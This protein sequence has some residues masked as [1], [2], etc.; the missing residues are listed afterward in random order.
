MLPAEY[1][2]ATPTSLITIVDYNGLCVRGSTKKKKDG[3]W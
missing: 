3:G 2:P 1:R